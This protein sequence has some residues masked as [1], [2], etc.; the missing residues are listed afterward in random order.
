MIR[1]YIDKNFPYLGKCY[2]SCRD[3]WIRR[4]IKPYRSSRGFIIHG[5]TSLYYGT[6]AEQL[7]E[8]SCELSV[9]LE[10][11]KKVDVL[12]DVGANVGIFSL[13]ASKEIPEVMA[14]EA[15]GENYRNLVRNLFENKITNI[16]AYLVALS[17]QI[18]IGNLFGDGE[19]ASLTDGWG[20]KSSN[21]SNLVMMNLLDNLLCGRFPGKKILIKM[22]VEGHEYQVL[23]GAGL[24]LSRT[25]RPVWMLEHGFN[26]HFSGIN[27][28]FLDVF[29][30]FWKL[31][32]RAYSIEAGLR[33]VT[34][35]DVKLWLTQNR[36]DF[37]GINYLFL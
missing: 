28:H 18:G 17:D 35:N 27:P 14:I 32:Y 6:Q 33:E 25:P 30:L 31:G 12:V 8:T 13:I 21:Y 15:C 3:K 19:M 36:R 29:E 5:D 37:G 1:K 16:E 4:R 7:R 23:K 34:P 10:Q 20:N 22:D 9:F 2:R 24:S 11:L 26:E